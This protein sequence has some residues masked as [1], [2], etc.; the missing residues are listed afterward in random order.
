V[1][2]HIGLWYFLVREA[3][4]QTYGPART[5]ANLSAWLGR[6]AKRD[7][8]QNNEGLPRS[9]PCDNRTGGQVNHKDFNGHAVDMVS[10]PPCATIS[11]SSVSMKLLLLVSLHDDV[12]PYTTAY[13]LSPHCVTISAA[14]CH[15]LC[16]IISRSTIH[17]TAYHLTA[18]AIHRMSSPSTL[19]HYMSP[20]ILPY[21]QAFHQAFLATN[22]HIEV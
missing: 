11:V 2:S 17:A 12:S 13:Y 21:C 3:P 10:L 20:H 22:A 1:R 9:L 14:S 19:G 5:S 7:S 8:L 15:C 16:V 6:N 4:L 18:S